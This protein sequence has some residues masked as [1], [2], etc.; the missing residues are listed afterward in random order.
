MKKWV[1]NHFHPK[2][3]ILNPKTWTPKHLN[4]WTPKH[5]NPW[6]RLSTSTDLHGTSPAFGQR[7]STWRPVE[8][9]KA[10]LRHKHG[11][12]CFCWKCNRMKLLL[13][14]SVIGWKC[15]WMR[16]SLDE[17]VLGRMFIGWKRFWMKVFCRCR[18]ML[19]QRTLQQPRMDWVALQLLDDLRRSPQGVWRTSWA[20]NRSCPHL[21][22]PHLAKTAFGQKNPNLAILVSCIW[23]NRIWP[24]L[25]F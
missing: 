19:W 4:P 23:P 6:P 2:P 11:L 12:Y 8:T 5:P 25:V 21:A 7:C 3:K 20:N 10:G 16:N 13:V 15:H 1:Q 14:E 9:W 18:S 17:K 24:E 22:K